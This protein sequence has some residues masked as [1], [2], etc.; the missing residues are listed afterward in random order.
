[1]R[2]K[3]QGATAAML[4]FAE[5]VASG[6]SQYEAYRTAYPNSGK[7]KRE[8]ID[9]KASKLVRHKKVAPLIAQVREQIRVN[10][11]DAATYTREK[12]LAELHSA[13]EMAGRLGKP[14]AMVQAAIGKSRV[15]GLLVDEPMQ[16]ITPLS[17]RTEDELRAKAFELG[18]R[19][20]VEIGEKNGRVVATQS[21]AKREP[22]PAAIVSTAI[23]LTP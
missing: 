1:M 14:N 15:A 20:G 11:A 6:M 7:A 3:A 9:Q 10:M 17:S 2:G 21:K 18:M 8:T 13:F 16:P 22:V 5:L 4:K 19:L 23:R 12:A